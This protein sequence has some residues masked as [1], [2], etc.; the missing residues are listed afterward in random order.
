[1]F[2]T[3]EDSAEG[4]DTGGVADGFE[5][6]QDCAGSGEPAEIVNREAV[7]VFEGTGKEGGAD[8]DRVG[9]PAGD[10]LF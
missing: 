6:C 1:M 9:E 3:P 7:L 10:L 8:V 5:V 4:V 2:E